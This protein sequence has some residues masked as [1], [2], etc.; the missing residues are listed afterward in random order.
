MLRVPSNVCG[1]VQLADGLTCVLQSAVDGA[2][3]N[4]IMQTCQQQVNRD[5]LALFMLGLALCLLAVLGLMRVPQRM[6]AAVRR[7]YHHIITV[8]PARQKARGSLLG[9]VMFMVHCLLNALLHL[10]QRSIDSITVLSRDVTL[11]SVLLRH[12]PAS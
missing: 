1:C 7:A 9:N 2:G 11:F 5:I 4:C 10:A 8:G 12:L 6:I 3:P